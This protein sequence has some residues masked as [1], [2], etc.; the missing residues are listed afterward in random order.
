MGSLV[1]GVAN[2]PTTRRT[3]HGDSGPNEAAG[4]ARSEE[5][6]LEGASDPAL[7]A[8]GRELRRADAFRRRLHAGFAQKARYRCAA[9][10]DLQSAQRI[11]DLRV[12]PAGIVTRR[13]EHECADFG[14]F[15]RPARLANLRAVVLCA[16]S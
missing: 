8:L 6:D 10:L 11:A 2:Q 5:R 3:R 12:S 16:A 1:E 9:D 4:K 13:I 15:A 7:G 14:W